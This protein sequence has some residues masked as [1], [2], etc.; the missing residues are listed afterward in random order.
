M[1][2]LMMTFATLL[3]FLLFLVAAATFVTFNTSQSYVSI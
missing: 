2:F 1:Y 3:F